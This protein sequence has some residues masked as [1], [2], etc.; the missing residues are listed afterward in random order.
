MDD[1]LKD[2]NLED[3]HVD[4][5]DGT[6]KKAQIEADA[7]QAEK[8]R[9]DVAAPPSDKEAASPSNEEAASSLDKEE[10]HGEATVNADSSG[11]RSSIPYGRTT[12]LSD[13]VPKISEKPRHQI[14][15]MQDREISMILKTQGRALSQALM[16]IAGTRQRSGR[17]WMTAGA[18]FLVIALLIIQVYY[19][20][21]ELN[22]G[23]ELSA[24]IS[25]RE[26]LLEE[27]RKLR[28]E[29]RVLSRRDNLEAVA[30]K[31]LGMVTIRPEQVLI[32][33]LNKKTPSDPSN[34]KKR[35]DGLDN[36]KRIG[37]E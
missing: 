5:M 19:R 17:L 14:R 28:I 4:A 27:N 20:H 29:L 33:D 34:P 31:Q 35:I 12:K 15:T 3:L 24:A 32:Y 18:M 6:A 16:S 13:M 2:M 1:K 8:G 23:Y 30:G 7:D 21:R 25:Q 11:E 22:L 10:S 37:E 26:A 36:V 9:T